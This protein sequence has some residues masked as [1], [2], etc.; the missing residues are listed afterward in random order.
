M[1]RL[2]IA[3]AT[4]LGCVLALLVGLAVHG[5]RTGSAARPPAPPPAPAPQASLSL[6][7]F[8]LTETAGDETRWD[9][10]AAEGEYFKE[11]QLALLR[12]VE[13]TF[14]ARDGRTLTVRG[15]TGRLMT[16]TKNIALSGNVVATSSDGYRVTTDALFYT[17]RTR[18]ISGRGPVEL[19]GETMEVSG[20]GITIRLE[21]RTVSIPQSVSSTVRRLAEGGLLEPRLARRDAAA[22]GPS[23]ARP[24]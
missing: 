2:R 4:S 22:A 5:Y 17:D 13:V 6:N 7:G 11:R 20:V 19:V 8:H 21:E 3:F 12:D 24:R 14:F 23:D 10:R 15:D 16:D 9:L 18:S 1:R